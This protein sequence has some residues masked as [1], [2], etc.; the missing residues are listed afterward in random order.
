MIKIGDWLA[1][2]H[3]DRG[4]KPTGGKVH[5]H[6]K[7]RRRELGSLPMQTRIGKEKMREIRTRG[8]GLKRKAA[9]V[10][11]ANVYDPASKKAT[12]SKIIDIVRNPAN[13]HYVRRGIVTKGS[14]IKTE[15]GTARVTSRPSQ[16]G[17]VN[18]VLT[19]EK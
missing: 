1:R 13:I 18:A 12:K 5:V 19:K 9:A 3:G 6:R 17:I 10:Q 14:V 16:H 15:L 11:Y 7:K 2:W 4:K 8:K